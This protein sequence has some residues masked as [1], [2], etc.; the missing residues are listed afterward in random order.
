M[1]AAALISTADEALYLA[2]SAGRARYHF[3]DFADA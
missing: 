3:R 1:K 2:K